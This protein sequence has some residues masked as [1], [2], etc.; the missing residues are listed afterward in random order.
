MKIQILPAHS[1][2]R[3]VD[4][5]ILQKSEDFRKKG[6]TKKNNPVILTACAYQ[7]DKRLI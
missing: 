3:E 4:L 5:R 1:K 6:T 2:I 7:S